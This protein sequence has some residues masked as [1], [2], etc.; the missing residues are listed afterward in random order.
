MS[1]ATSNQRE[2]SQKRVMKVLLTLEPYSTARCLHHLHKYKTLTC[3]SLVIRISITWWSG[4]ESE[5]IIWFHTCNTDEQS[6]CAGGV[7]IYSPWACWLITCDTYEYVLLIEGVV[8]VWSVNGEMFIH[9]SIGI[10]CIKCSTDSFHDW[11]RDNRYIVSFL[12]FFL[13]NNLVF[14]NQ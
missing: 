4:I 7:F 11:T 12:F 13:P 9:Y 8:D 10:P 6:V 3:I 1:S 2:N 5:W 14:L